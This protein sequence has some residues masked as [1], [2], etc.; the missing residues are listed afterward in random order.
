MPSPLIRPIKSWASTEVDVETA[1]TLVLA[2]NPSRRGATFVNN[3][4]Q[5]M[6]FGFG[7]AAVLGLG[8]LLKANG[9]TYEMNDTNLF[10][11]A[12]YAIAT[13]G[14]KKL[15]VDEGI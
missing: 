2:D 15:A 12:I 8:K 14:A 13:G 5:D 10:T 11:G 7:V 1:S 3:S 4:N 9:G 6:S